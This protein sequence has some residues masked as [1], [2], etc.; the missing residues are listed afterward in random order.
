MCTQQNNNTDEFKSSLYYKGLY[1]SEEGST[2]NPHTFKLDKLK[3]TRVIFRLPAYKILPPKPVCVY[4]KKKFSEELYSCV[5]CERACCLCCIEV[6]KHVHP[7][8]VFQGLHEHEAGTKKEY[9]KFFFK[10]NNGVEC[11]FCKRNTKVWYKCAQCFGND[12]V[13][14]P[15]CWKGRHMLNTMSKCTLFSHLFYYLQNGCY[16][17]EPCKSLSVILKE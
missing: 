5:I 12:D 1:I 17:M 7:F 14:C 13:F 10:E 8:Y 6:S 4:C 16:K 9:I 11:S 3:N 15:M 2:L